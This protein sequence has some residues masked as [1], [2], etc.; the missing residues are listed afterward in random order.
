MHKFNEEQRCF[1][2]QFFITACALLYIEVRNPFLFGEGR[3]FVGITYS[4]LN[5]SISFSLEMG[6]IMKSVT[7]L[8]LFALPISYG[9][10]ED[11][12]I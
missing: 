8:I 7:K 6:L 9:D 12:T 2:A 10:M 5:I 4:I 3:Y 11:E 1:L